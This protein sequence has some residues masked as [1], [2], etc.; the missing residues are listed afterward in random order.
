MDRIPLGVLTYK[1]MKRKLK[2]LKERK[3]SKTTTVKEMA[4]FVSAETGFREDD[5]LIV[6]KSIIKYV[7]VSIKGGLAVSF[8]KLGI[9]YPL[10]KPKRIVMSMNGG[11]GTPTKMS[12]NSRWQMK[13][14]TSDSIDRELAEIEVSD[15]ETE[16]LYEQ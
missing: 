5:I 4:K 14:K 1:I 6:I 15:K 3:P 11:I 2:P 16:N 9:F 12:M 10:I 8:P 7:Y 13:F